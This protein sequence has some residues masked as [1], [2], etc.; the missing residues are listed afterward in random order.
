LLVCASVV[1]FEVKKDERNERRKPENI[2]RI[3]KE[4]ERRKKRIFSY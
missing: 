1:H 2:K 4:R 3:S